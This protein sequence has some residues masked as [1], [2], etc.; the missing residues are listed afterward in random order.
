MPKAAVT[1]ATVPTRSPTRQ[2]L[3]GIT[4]LLIEDSRYFSDAVRLL[5]IRSGARMRRAD[6]LASARKHVRIYRPDVVIVDMGLPDGSG[7]EFVTEVKA[8]ADAPSVIAISGFAMQAAKDAAITSG[9][10]CFLEKPFFDLA[11]FQQNILAVLPNT[12]VDTRF[13][14]RVAGTY[15]VPDTEA[16]QE[17][18]SQMSVILK[19]AESAQSM[20]GMEYVAKFLRSVGRVSHDAELVKIAGALSAQLSGKADWRAAAHDLLR[21]IQLRLDDQPQ[22]PL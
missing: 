15:V 3:L 4:I 20:D 13:V 8:T 7:L 17:D 14:P 18:L 10:D 9:A 21:T 16:L 22:T 5:S 11:S 19:D 12:E 2:P 6:C 1:I